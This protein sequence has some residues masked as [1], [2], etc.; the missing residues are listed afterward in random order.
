MELAIRWPIASNTA[1]PPAAVLKPFAMTF[2]PE[3]GLAHQFR[4]RVNGA[5]GVTPGQT[6]ACGGIGTIISCLLT[7][8]AGALVVGGS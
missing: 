2:F 3:A 5:I 4:G 6:E 1:D 7:P 8:Y